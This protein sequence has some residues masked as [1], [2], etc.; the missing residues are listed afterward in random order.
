MRTRQA[1]QRVIAAFGG[2]IVLTSLVHAQNPAAP[3][4]GRGRGGAQTPQVVSPEIQTDRSM[5]FRIYAP[6]AQSVRLSGS[7]IPQLAG[8]GRGA[9]PEPPLH[10]H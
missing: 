6:N 9:A 10:R 3:A 1:F 5:T 7:D 2:V 8:G 4:A